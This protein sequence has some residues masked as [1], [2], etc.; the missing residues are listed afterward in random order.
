ME[1]PDVMSLSHYYRIFDYHLISN[2]ILPELQQDF[3]GNVSPE[4][5]V[6]TVTMQAHGKHKSRHI[7]WFHHWETPQGATSIV[8]G[9]AEGAYFL[10]FPHIAVF[11]IYPHSLTVVGY[12]EA[13]NLSIVRHMLL[14]QVIPRLLFH[15]GEL[16]IHGSAVLADDA[17][18][19]FLG[20][21]GQGKST[22]ALALCTLGFPLL[23]DDCLLLR[24][25]DGK[26]IVWANYYGAR[27]LQ[28]SVMYLVPGENRNSSTGKTRLD[29]EAAGYKHVGNSQGGG[30]LLFALG[31]SDYSECL[32]VSRLIG[33]GK[34]AELLKHCFYLDPTD[35]RCHKE[36]FV[37]AL[38]L[39]K[40][41]S[42]GMFSL[43]YPRVYEKLHGVCEKIV[44]FSQRMQVITP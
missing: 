10:K 35:P 21:T 12:P 7:D 38:R 16:V 18:L 22:L 5:R 34:V 30:V 27:L 29:L 17:T 23:S 42:V 13:A 14:D 43:T 39:L 36:Q 20:A 31:Y 25:K 44:E 6:I 2:C 26:I 28:E 41:E 24:V 37:N 33:G 40:M 32:A 3:C 4:G 11:Q 15:R 19:I 9:R 8:C 1:A